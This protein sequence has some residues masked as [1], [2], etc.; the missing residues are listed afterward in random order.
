[1]QNPLQRINKTENDYVRYALLLA[2]ILLVT[3]IIPKQAK[4]KYEFEQGKPWMHED[5]VAPFS[6]AIQKSQ[7]QIQREREVI[8][9]NFKPFYKQN[10]KIMQDRKQ[11]F[12]SIIK[13]LSPNE[14]GI[15]K[16]EKEY[17][18]TRGNDIIE[19]IYEKGIIALDTNIRSK[20]KEYIITELRK[21]IAEDKQLQEYYTLSEARSSVMD[22]VN[23]D[24]MLNKAWFIR[25]IITSLEP[26]IL[27]DQ[28]LSEKKLNE[29]LENVSPTRGMV[30]QDEKIITKG[31]I[32]TTERMQVLTSLKNE[33]EAKH[34]QSYL[35]LI[36]YLVLVASLFIMYSIHLEIFHRDVMS[37]TR[38][39]VLI[40][41][42]VL[43]F[44]ALTAFVAKR[45]MVNVYLIP[46]TIIPIVLLA[47]FG[48]RI[49]FVTYF[50]V[51]LL[52]GL[53]VPNPYEFVLVQTMAGFTAMLSMARIRYISQFFISAL[54]I[55]M[56]YCL[57]YLGFSF[58]KSGLIKTVEWDIF[59]WFG[60]NFILTLL[61]YPLIYANEKIFGFLSDISLLELS[62]INNKLL[63][64]L[65]LRAP[66]TF[67][68]SL[69]VAN[70]AEAVIDRIGG[71]ALL[72]RVGA[73]Y[74]DVGK[75]HNPEYFIENQK[76]SY[77]PHEQLTDLQSADMIIGH[78]TKGVET[79]QE[80]NLPKRVI[81]FI[82]THH[83]TTRVEYF[84]KHYV[85]EHTGEEVDDTAFRYPGPKPS[86]KETAVV[87]I[88]DSV[89]AA[90]R[91]LKEPDEKQIDNVVDKIIDNKIQ[92]NQFDYATI[93]INEIN[94]TRRILKKLVKSI[95]HIRI[96]YPSEGE[97]KKII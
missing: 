3:F 55:F 38:S 8:Q 77:N 62:D 19:E 10:T 42:N 46:Y 84:Y 36:G 33:Y 80:Y 20:P 22:R 82:R 93:T 90:S 87:M 78:V 40:L 89:E 83:G 86:S 1:M 71:N 50:L 70:L 97:K 61:A 54:L 35:L 39:L 45:Q 81:E 49:A 88:V 94:A 79:A 13:Q 29:L 92:D 31:S 47:F 14:T 48:L 24:T 63:K 73:L 60:G 34:G 21:N 12:I 5:L 16:E 58:I 25:S 43:L 65:F 85:Q 2:C 30:R 11:R 44:T 6:F 75:L 28:D 95:Y 76:H 9:E 72:T 27:Y 59:I 7:S 74:H 56:T 53:V 52:C 17:Y 57:V 68:H 15:E 91:S 18:L 67:Q 69:Q 64:E 96:Q 66:G 23:A 41:I 51:I 32:I 4:F 26:N 37:S